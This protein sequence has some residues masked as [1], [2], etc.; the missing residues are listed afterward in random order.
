MPLWLSRQSHPRPRPRPSAGPV[1]CRQANWGTGQEHW[2]PRLRSTRGPVRRLSRQARPVMAIGQIALG[3]VGCACR[4]CKKLI[5]G[6]SPLSVTVAPK[7]NSS[8][9]TDYGI[10]SCLILSVLCCAVFKPASMMIKKAVCR[11]LY[12]HAYRAAPP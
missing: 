4:Q 9:N 8:W 1:S 6:S 10:A 3:R 7:T 11:T 12:R 5:D 2:Q